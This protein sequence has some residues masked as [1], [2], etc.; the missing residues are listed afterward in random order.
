ME[1]VSW[2]W[3]I[4]DV[5]SVMEICGSSTSHYQPDSKIARCSSTL[6]Y[7]QDSKIARCSSTLRSPS[8]SSYWAPPTPIGMPAFQKV[9]IFLSSSLALIL[10]WFYILA[11]DWGTDMMYWEF[12]GL[13]GL[14]SNWIHLSH[15][16]GTL[17]FQPDWF[18]IGDSSCWCAF[19]GQ[20]C[21]LV[22][23]ADGAVWWIVCRIGM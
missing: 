10:Y 1:V 23:W 7:Q 4:S 11:A 19:V 2:K 18:W 12:L 5:F 6:A 15:I 3:W 13:C 8:S 22:L 20:C 16:L 21:W 14:T 17:T 9:S